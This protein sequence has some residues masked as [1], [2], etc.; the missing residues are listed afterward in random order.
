M[1]IAKLTI[2]SDAVRLKGL[3]QQFSTAISGFEIH[4]MP[5]PLSPVV[6]MIDCFLPLWDA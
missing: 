4:K 3:G 2:I 5:L 6:P 1:S